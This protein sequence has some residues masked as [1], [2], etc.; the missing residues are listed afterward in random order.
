MP[1]PPELTVGLVKPLSF[2]GLGLYRCITRALEIIRR[3]VYI[4]SV[5][6]RPPL[7][8]N[9]MSRTR[10]IIL[11]AFNSIDDMIIDLFVKLCKK[12]KVILI[13]CA[14]LGKIAF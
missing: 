4:D 14:C 12:E 1:R 7:E 8:R 10:K 13:Y 5:S 6:I 11:P 9:R 2:G 3:N